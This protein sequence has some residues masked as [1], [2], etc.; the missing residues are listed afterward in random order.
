MGRF[1]LKIKIIFTSSFTVVSL[2]E[3]KLIPYKPFRY[4][5]NILRRTGRL[6]KLFSSLNSGSRLLKF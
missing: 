3:T 1:E 2:N 4:T 5:H 6:I